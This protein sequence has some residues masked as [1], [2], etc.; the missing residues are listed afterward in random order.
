MF[1]VCHHSSTLELFSSDTK[2]YKEKMKMKDKK[3]LQVEKFK[4]K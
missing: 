4:E 2:I 3:R 1:V